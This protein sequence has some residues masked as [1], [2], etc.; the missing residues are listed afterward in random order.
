MRRSWVGRALSD[1]VMTG[2][3]GSSESAAWGLLLAPQV[4][5]VARHW[6]RVAARFERLD[7]RRPQIEAFSG[8]LAVLE[9]ASFEAPLLRSLRA[10]LDVAGRPPSHH[11]RRLASATGWADLRF[12]ALLHPFLNL[13]FMWDWH[14]L[15]ALERWNRSA[16][17]RVESWLETIGE[18]EALASLAVL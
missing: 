13:L 6:Q 16:G 3:F 11:M 8:I 10:R 2:M 14:V 9:R 4:V 5:L 15:W 17:A 12:Q 1:P 7:A 18:I